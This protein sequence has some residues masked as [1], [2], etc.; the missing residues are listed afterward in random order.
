MQGTKGRRL[1]LPPSLRPGDGRM[2][3]GSDEDS[4]ARFLVVWQLQAPPEV[5]CRIVMYRAWA[6]AAELQQAQ[7]CITTDAVLTILLRVD[8]RWEWAV[9]AVLTQNLE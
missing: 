5:G 4:D 7:V 3:D 6:A 8:P 9:L 2:D 1:P